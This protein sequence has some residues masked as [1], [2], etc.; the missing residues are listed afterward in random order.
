MV[1]VTKD[2]VKFSTNGDIGSANI[3]C[4]QNTAVDKARPPRP[5]VVSARSRSR[6]PATYRAPSLTACPP[7]PPPCLTP[8]AQVEEQ[9]VI[10]LHEPVT[11][12][13]ALRYLNSF[14][15]ARARSVPACCTQLPCW[16]CA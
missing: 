6:A 15:K 4:R 14:T 2:G 3:T 9:T 16:A 7:A 13:F 10:D 11:L 12:S 8:G 1:S 5:R